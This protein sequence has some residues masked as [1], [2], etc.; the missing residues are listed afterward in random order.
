[1]K[2]IPFLLMCLLGLVPLVI[3]SCGDDDDEIVNGV[4]KKYAEWKKLNDDWLLE[5]QNRKNPDGTNYFTEVVAPWDR[6]A[7]VYMHWYNDRALT[8]GNAKPYYTSTVDVKYKGMLYNDEPFDSSYQRTTPA[9]GV[10]RTKLGDDVIEGW[11]I[12]LCAMR[13]CDSCRVIIPSNVGY[14][15]LSMGEID[16]YAV[17]QFDIKLVGIPKL[18]LNAPR[19]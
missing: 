16:P 6:S 5:Q 8:E 9:V 4:S 14:G 13:V 7:K 12:A 3:S 10:F 1:M 19:R 17:L 15:T 18:E 2:K 11:T